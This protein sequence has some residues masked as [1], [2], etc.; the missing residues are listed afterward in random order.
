MSLKPRALL[1]FFNRSKQAAH[2]CVEDILRQ[3]NAREPQRGL[4]FASP[5]L[6]VRKEGRDRRCECFRVV[7][8]AERAR[9]GMM[10]T[11][12]DAAGRLRGANDRNAMTSAVTAVAT[13]VHP[14]HG[15]MKTRLAAKMLED[16]VVHRVV[17]SS[18]S[19]IA[20]AAIGCF[21]DGANTAIR[22]HIRI[23]IGHS[24]LSPSSPSQQSSA[25]SLFDDFHAARIGDAGGRR[26]DHLID[27]AAGVRHA[28][29]EHA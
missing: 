17:E 15:A 5:K 20:T 22:V 24:L 4:R 8:H 11:I 13:P 19:S 12:D 7:M 18:R 23:D 2:Q 6:L 16:L 27:W 1:P 3:R 14:R 29:I 10:R 28:A 9:L 26:K 21:V 25:A